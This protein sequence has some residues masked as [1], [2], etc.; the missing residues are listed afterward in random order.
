MPPNLPRLSSV[1]IDAG[2][3][4]FSL[5][6]SFIAA[7]AAGLAPAWNA[8]HTNIADALRGAS[9]G[10]V[11]KMR[12]R[13]QRLLVAGQFAM[14]TLLVV[15][16]AVL[17]ISYWKLQRVD[18]GFQA[19]HV[20]TASIDN[21]GSLEKLREIPGVEAVGAASDIFVSHVPNNTIAIEGRGELQA[22]PN[23]STIVAGDYFAVLKI[24]L[25]QG[26]VFD[27]D[28]RASTP[29]VAIVDQTMARRF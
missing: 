19:D 26:R 20:L 18:L 28:D 24:P 13:G 25:L 3:V 29:R 17:A 8:A 5:I 10:T 1:R 6:A 11:G 22:E 4:V 7:A 23:I 16:A 21:P 12:Q 14:T 15:V 9:K 27:V 2:V